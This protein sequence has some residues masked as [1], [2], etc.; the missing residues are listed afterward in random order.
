MFHRLKAPPLMLGLAIALGAGACKDTTTRDPEPDIATLQ[1]T[2]GTPSAQVVTV[3]S[4]PACQV[5]GGSIVLPVNTTVS[6]A[7]SFRNTAGAADPIANDPAVFRLS[8]D[9]GA[10][11]EPSPPSIVWARTGPFSGTLR[12]SATTTG[13]VEVAAFHIDEGHEDWGPCTVPLVV[14][15]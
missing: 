8:G 2:I 12:G 10:E 5:T 13:S 9:A 6:V 3:A 15:P 1:L 11:L 14:T 4:N 7:A